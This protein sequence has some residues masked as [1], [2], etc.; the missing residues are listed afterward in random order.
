MKVTIT[1]T[2]DEVAVIR[3]ALADRQWD[4]EQRAR[5][6]ELPGDRDDLTDEA[7]TC[8]DLRQKLWSALV[9]E[10]AA[11]LRGVKA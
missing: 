5:R 6:T 10:R 11:A 2:E 4:R 7:L 3:G 9:Q 8:K 1:L